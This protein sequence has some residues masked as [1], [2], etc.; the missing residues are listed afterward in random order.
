M[1]PTSHELTTLISI[2]E[3]GPYGDNKYRGNYAGDVLI[4]LIGF[5]QANG[6]AAPYVYDP[7]EGGM[8]SR[9]VC[10][11]LNLPYVGSDIHQGF[12]VVGDDLHDTGF[13][14]C[15]LHYPYWNMIDYAHDLPEELQKKDMSR[16]EWKEL[17]RR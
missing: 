12:D 14:L 2:P 4:K 5:L 15:I 1:I 7:M 11:S 3:R 17:S 10:S 8:T 6:I 13:D 9:D 16:M